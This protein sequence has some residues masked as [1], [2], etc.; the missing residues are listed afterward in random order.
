MN[1]KPTIFLIDIKLEE[2]YESASIENIILDIIHNIE[3]HIEIQNNDNPLINCSYMMDDIQN[4]Y[5]MVNIESISKPKLKTVNIRQ[6]IISELKLGTININFKILRNNYE[7]I[8]DYINKTMLNK[9][10]KQKNSIYKWREANKEKYL[11]T[12]HQYN[13]KK[14]ED[15]EKRIANLQRIKETNKKKKEEEQQ[16]TGIIKKVGRPSKYNS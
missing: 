14:Y 11:I 12:Q 2:I 7:N 3:H 16:R 6:K 9:Y 13:K 15:P 4:I 10:E 1:N 5:I 8:D